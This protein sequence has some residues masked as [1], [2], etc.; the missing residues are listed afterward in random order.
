MKIQQKV[1][2]IILPRC[3]FNRN[4]HRSILYGPQQLGGAAFRHRAVEQGV[5]Q[6]AYFIRQWCLKS[7]VGELLKCSVVW[8][9][10][11]VR[12]SYSVFQQPQIVLPHL[13]FKWN[14]SLLSFL[15][16][17][18]LSIHLDNTY[19]T[20]PQRQNDGYIMDLLMASN[21]YTPVELRKFNYCRLFLNVTTISDVAKPCGTTIDASLLD[22][23]PPCFRSRSFHPIVHQDSPSPNEWKLWRR[24]NLIWIDIY[25]ELRTPLG[26][27]LHPIH[28]QRNRHFAYQSS[29][30]LWI[31]QH[32]QDQYQ[33]N[34]V[35]WR[36]HRRMVQRSR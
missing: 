26:K 10:V 1:M 30:R 23:T 12:V 27:W 13:E 20:T 2:M 25:G 36:I 24:A 28:T 3:G 34:I 31:R 35:P 4:T 16:K 8:L 11:S 14:A 21:H 17:H 6:V 32:E 29:P 5:L 18:G 33:E 7:L 19:V 22:G 15:A 9:Q